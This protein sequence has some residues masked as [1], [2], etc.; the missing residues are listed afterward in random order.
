MAYLLDSNVLITAK[1]LYY[2]MDFCPGFWDWLRKA[3]DADKVF[4]VSKVKD[5]IT[6]GDDQLVNWVNSLPSD[7]FLQPQQSD[8]AAL[9]KIS[10]WVTSGKYDQAAISQFLQLTDYYL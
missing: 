9:Q 6:S 8:V 10:T 7:F 4:S 3:Y 2:G 5:E 1:N